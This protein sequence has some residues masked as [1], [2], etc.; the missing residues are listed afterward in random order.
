MPAIYH[1]QS[2]ISFTDHPRFANVRIAA[3]VTSRESRAVSVSLLAIAPGAEVPVHTH[4]PQVDSIYVVAGQGE[5]LVN[6]G[7]QQVMAGDHIFVPEKE[8]H[9][10]RNTGEAILRL[11]VHHSPPLL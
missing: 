1:S 2:Q 3:L 11:F 6:G 10:V 5:I 7:W 8:E 4:D 9:G